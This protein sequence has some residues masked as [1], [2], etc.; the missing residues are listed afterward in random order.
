MNTYDPYV[1][2]RAT[3]RRQNGIDIKPVL[4]A[5]GFSKPFDRDASIFKFGGGTNVVGFFFLR[6][7][8]PLKIRNH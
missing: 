7:A 2:E 5:M 1:C 4:A 6:R 3:G 8:A